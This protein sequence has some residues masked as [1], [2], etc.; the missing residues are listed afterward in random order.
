MLKCPHCS[1][2]GITS[3]LKC[4]EHSN[5]WEFTL[6]QCTSNPNHIIL[7][8]NIVDENYLE[9]IHKKLRYA[10]GAPVPQ[11]PLLD[12]ICDITKTTLS[13]MEIYD[14]F[15]KNANTV[16]RKGTRR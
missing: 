10:T 3:E 11:S 4:Y 12:T 9:T 8:A 1:A 13:I 15:S 6:L 7:S 2:N 16:T 5:H 14:E